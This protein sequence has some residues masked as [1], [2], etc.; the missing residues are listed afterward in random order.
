MRSQWVSGCSDR[1][2]GLDELLVER[3]NTM[4]SQCQA[5]SSLRSFRETLAVCLAFLNLSGQ[6]IMGLSVIGTPGSKGQDAFHMRE[7]KLLQMECMDQCYIFIVFKV[8]SLLP[9][10]LLTMHLDCFGMSCRVLAILALEMS[11]FSLGKS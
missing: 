11:A 8:Y 2:T 1:A 3:A 10:V 7:T 9:V 5:L 6:W 4:F